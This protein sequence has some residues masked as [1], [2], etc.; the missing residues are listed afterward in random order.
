MRTYAALG[1][2][3][4]A[5][6]TACTSTPQAETDPPDD[7]DAH[8]TRV[9]DRYETT[10]FASIDL[11]MTPQEVAQV[12]GGPSRKRNTPLT[13]YYYFD[14]YMF[15]SGVVVIDFSTA[16]DLPPKNWSTSCESLW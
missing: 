1:L 8:V 9:L 4:I 15:P 2:I 6:L 10:R 16:P 14:Q 11:G 3:V 13:W 5:M 7:M 12:A